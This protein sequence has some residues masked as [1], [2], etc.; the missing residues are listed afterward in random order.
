VATVLL[1]RHGRT[2][3][4]ASGVL[5]GRT[6]GV[7]LDDVGRRQAEELGIRMSALPI[8]AIVSSPLERCR[9]TASAL[10]SAMSASVRVTTDQ[11]LTECGYGDWTG[12]AL[13]DLAKEPLW[14][15]V[16]GQPSA[17]EFPGGES[18]RAMQARALDAVR[19][20]DAAVTESHGAGALWV[21]AVSHGDVIKAILAD[22][23]GSHLDSFQRI[24][25]D[26]G[27]VSVVS[28]TPQ[29]PFVVR[30]N[31]HGDLS[32]LAPKVRG[33]RRRRSTP[34]GDAPVGGGAGPD[35]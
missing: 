5:A 21:V 13:K 22:A 8:A 35:T 32:G 30:L 20:Y 26:P 1:V 3:A 9:Q 19:H 11:R 18:M 14:K 23:A 15:V 31:E 10:A 28:Y 6:P 24:V 25:V 2:S 16:Q 17:V 12:R 27:S 34:S 29:R 7:R 33:G 4:N